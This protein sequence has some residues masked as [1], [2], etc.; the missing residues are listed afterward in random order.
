MMRAVCRIYRARRAGWVCARACVQLITNAPHDT[1]TR[2]CT[3]M[4]KLTQ[5]AGSG[6][7]IGSSSSGG[8]LGSG[9]GGAGDPAR[10]PTSRGR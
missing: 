7:G 9:L 2:W 10:D 6:H 4:I 1:H 5:R 3:T 8:P